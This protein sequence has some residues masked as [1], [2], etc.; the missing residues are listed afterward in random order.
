MAPDDREIWYYHLSVSTT[1]VHVN[2]NK[3]KSTAYGFWG[4]W[5]DLFLV[6][7]GAGFGCLRVGWFYGGWGWVRSVLGGGVVC[8]VC[9]WTGCVR[10]GQVRVCY[11]V[12]V[13]LPL[14]GVIGVWVGLC[15]G[16]RFHGGVMS[17]WGLGVRELEQHWST[18][19]R[20]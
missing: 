9:Y 6:G 14:G 10:S 8:G 18:K 16:G 3:R 19:K 11:V 13:F 4:G 7:W 12:G 1:F 17:R 5:G 20:E 15:G 2:S